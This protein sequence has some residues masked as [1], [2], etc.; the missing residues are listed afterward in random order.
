[1]EF[2]EIYLV[3]LGELTLKGGNL[4]DFEKRLVQNVQLYLESVKSRVTLRA[5][6]MYVE[7]NNDGCPAVEF[8]L[9]HLI[10]IT[11]WAKTRTC[12]KTLESIKNACMEEAKIAVSKG[13]KTFKIDTRRTDKSFPLNS[14]ETSCEAAQDI[15]NSHY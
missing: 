13:C 4:K 10:G 7:C 3:K 15:F 12:E 6:R 8:T 1:M 14:Y 5:G 9:S 11:G 2:S